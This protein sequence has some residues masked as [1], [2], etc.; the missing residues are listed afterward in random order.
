M[1]CNKKIYFVQYKYIFITNMKGK[2]KMFFVKIK[3]NDTFALDNKKY[4]T[5]DLIA[6]NFKTFL[7]C[8]TYCINY[9]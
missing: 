8:L 9:I 6:L 3:N 2:R 4:E 5:L 1:L 7:L